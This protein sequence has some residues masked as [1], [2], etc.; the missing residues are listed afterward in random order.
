MAKI[1]ECSRVT[2]TSSPCGSCA[3]GI[4][5][6]HTA[7][8]HHLQSAAAEM[9]DADHGKSEGM[10]FNRNQGHPTATIAIGSKKPNFN[11]EATRWLGIWLDSHLTLIKHQ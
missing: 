4:T 9:R 8:A 11:K 6:S 1:I 2:S 3:F 7:V 5:T 10:L